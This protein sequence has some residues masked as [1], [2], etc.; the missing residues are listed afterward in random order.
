M[1][2][3]N[4]QILTE[5]KSITGTLTQIQVAHGRLDERHEGMKESIDSL[6]EKIGEQ[7]GRV[8]ALEHFKT[9]I[10]TKIKTIPATIS[11]IFGIV[12]VLIGLYLRTK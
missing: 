6:A 5:I 11:T 3:V 2:G 12:T 8:S 1:A 9:T 10:M 7:S 4:D